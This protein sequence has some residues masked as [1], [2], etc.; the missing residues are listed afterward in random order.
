VSRVLV[1][2]DVAIVISGGV[3]RMPKSGDNV[4]LRDS[5]A[6][7]SG[8]GANVALNL[9]SLAVEAALASGVGG[10]ALG[11]LALRDL[12]DEGVDVSLIERESQPTGTMLLLVEPSGERTMVGA[13]GASERFALDADTLERPFDWVH[14]SGYTLLD[15]EMAGRCARLL[16]DARARGIP[17]SVDLE[18]LGGTP[19][20]ATFGDALIFCNGHDLATLIGSDDIHAAAEARRDTIVVKS[21]RD[22]CSLLDG[23]RVT[24]VTG[25]A[26]GRPVDTTGAG[27]AFDAAFIAARLRGLSLEDAC[28]WGNVAGVLKVRVRGPRAALDAAEVERLARS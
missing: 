24:H 28:R 18:G 11:E 2:G 19:Q 21:G 13:R 15:G 14:V 26:A 7:V 6:L 10:D 17:S 16:A 27:D 22:G 23:G 3:D 5:R 20:A 1:V 25:L 12:T 9:R 8:V 4:L